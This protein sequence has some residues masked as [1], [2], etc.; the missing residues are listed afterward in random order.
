M[1]T[2]YPTGVVYRTAIIGGMWNNNAAVDGFQFLMSSGNI[3]RGTIKIYG[4]Q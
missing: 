4:I 2:F 1:E 3:T